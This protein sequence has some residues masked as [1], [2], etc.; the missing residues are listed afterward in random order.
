M[1]LP[2]IHNSYL[3]ASA[4][5]LI[6][7]HLNILQRH[8]FDDTSLRSQLQQDTVLRTEYLVLFDMVNILVNVTQAKFSLLATT[9]GNIDDTL[10]H[11]CTD[12][13]RRPFLPVFQ[14]G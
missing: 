6:R 7:N 12:F 4:W 2:R 11:T 10:F 8:D 13:Q 3:F 9:A 5:K 14:T 1:A